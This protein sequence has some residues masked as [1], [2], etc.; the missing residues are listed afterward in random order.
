MSSDAAYTS[1]NSGQVALA[2]FNEEIVA[3]LELSEDTY[4]L[5]GR[6]CIGNYDG[7]PQTQLLK[8]RPAMKPVK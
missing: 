4:L 7:D 2:N 6:V 1:S 3:R 5:F 8:S